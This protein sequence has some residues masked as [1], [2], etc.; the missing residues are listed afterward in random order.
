VSITQADLDA[1]KADILAKVTDRFAALGKLIVPDPPSPPVTTPRI[2]FASHRYWLQ[3]PKQAADFYDFQDGPSWV[4][5][6]FPAAAQ[7]FRYATTCRS[8]VTDPSAYRQL[9]PVTVS[10]AYLARRASGTVVS[11]TANSDQ[12]LDIGDPALL[13]S[14]QSYLGSIT[15]KFDGLYLDEIDETWRYGY[16]TASTT[17]NWANDAEW[18]TDLVVF[19]QGISQ[20]LHSLGK[21]L[22]INLGSSLPATH[23]FVSGVLGAADAVNLEYF[24]G[25]EKIGLGPATGSDLLFLINRVQWLEKTLGKP[26]HVHVSTTSQTVVDEGFV[27]WLLGTEFIGSFTASLDYGGDFLLPSSALLANARKLGA[28]LGGMNAGSE[29]AVVSRSFT[30]GK[31]S[32]NTNSLAFS[33]SIVAP[34]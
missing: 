24:V 9:V 33:V 14:V 6:D 30:G 15:S 18:Q 3:G 2:K 7:T 10:S 1:A 34:N 25:R 28:P 19:V 11:R 5:T 8:A 17:A 21:K 12:L 20:T 22:W 23:P 27:A 31:V 29:G 26:A 16:P 13:R 32:L 4:R